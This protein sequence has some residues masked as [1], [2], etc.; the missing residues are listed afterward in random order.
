[1]DKGD[2]SISFIPTDLQLADIFTKPLA[3]ER[4]NFIRLELGM[5]NKDALT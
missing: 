3:E 1:M 2:V 4:F 5:L